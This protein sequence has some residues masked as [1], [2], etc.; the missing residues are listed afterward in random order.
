MPLQVWWLS[1][2][3]LN[4]APT[5]TSVSHACCQCLTQLAFGTVPT[6]VSVQVYRSRWNAQNIV[7]IFLVYQGLEIGSRFISLALLALVVRKFFFLVLVWLW[8]SRS[9]I[10]YRSDGRGNKVLR[11]R[12]QL[13]LVGMPFMD[14]VMDRLDSYNVGVV[15][16]TAEF[17]A[18]VVIGNLVPTNK[19]D[20]V[21]DN[22]RLV[23]TCVAVGC[24]TGKLVLT[25]LIV[26][27]FKREFVFG[28]GNEQQEE[29]TT[30][31]HHPHVEN[32][33]GK[34]DV[35][36]GGGSRV[37]DVV[38]MNV[39]EEWL[40]HMVDDD[41][42]GKSRDAYA[43]DQPPAGKKVRDARVDD[44]EKPSSV[45]GQQGVL[46]LDVDGNKE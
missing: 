5:L 45:M 37:G 35:E 25:W 42:E 40:P 6:N 1:S 43:H 31:R 9:V 15:F 29:Q 12:S 38:C 10:L 32:D 23:W 33:G 14:S 11:F 7:W 46:P 16:T 4:A 8:F 26:R 24:M 17:L 30:A 39:S 27:P 2:L 36:R 18:C 22:I 3:C 34:G 28:H 44:E 20:N 21:Y 19:T 41:G 13:R